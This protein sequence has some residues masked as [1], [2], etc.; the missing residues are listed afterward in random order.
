MRWQ[1]VLADVLVWIHLAYVA[2]VVLGQAA[3][4]A[5]L[6]FRRPWARGFWLR[7][8]HVAMIFVVVV[9]A[10]LRVPCPLTV[11]ERDLRRAA[12]ENVAEISFVGYWARRVLFFQA[13]PWVFTLIYSAFGALVL[14]TWILAPP[15]WKVVP[16]SSA[17]PSVPTPAR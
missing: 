8:V 5:G 2:F 10:W 16:P 13:E 1:S 6:A 9:E 4:L 17:R 14:A 3:I 12:G 11:W 15:R 7:M